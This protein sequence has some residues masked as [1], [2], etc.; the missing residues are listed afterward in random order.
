MAM[1]KPPRCPRCES[2]RH[3]VPVLYH[4]EDDPRAQAKVAAG[5][6]VFGDDFEPDGDPEWCCTLCDER[7]S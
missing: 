6:A 7:F 2:T 5:K 3:V 1:T 4:G